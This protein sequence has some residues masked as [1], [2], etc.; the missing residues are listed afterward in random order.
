MI[1]NRSSFKTFFRSLR[2]GV[3]NLPSDT[4]SQAPIGFLLLVDNDPYPDYI[5]D[6]DSDYLST[7]P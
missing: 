1:F 3:F 7:K 2:D 5:I 6:N 4:D